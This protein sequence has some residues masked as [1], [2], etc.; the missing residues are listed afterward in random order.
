MFDHLGPIPKIKLRKKPI[1][2]RAYFS[3][4]LLA[5]AFYL[6]AWSVTS[7]SQTVASPNVQPQVLVDLPV[8]NQTIVLGSTNL[9]L[10]TLQIKT[11]VKG[12]AI[13]NIDIKSQGIYQPE[14]L[15]GLK[16]FH[17]GVQLGQLS[18]LDDQGVLHFDLNGY[19]LPNGDNQI[20]L[21]A[22]DS[23]NLLAGDILN[24]SL[25]DASSI[26]WSYDNK[27]YLAQGAWP[28][29][30]GTI[31]VVDQG[32]IWAYNNLNKKDLA[33]FTNDISKLAEFNLAVDGEGLDLEKLVFKHQTNAD[34][35]SVFS[36]SS[37][38]MTLASAKAKDGL[39]EFV[40][41]KPLAIAINQPLNLVLLGQLATGDY[42]LEL[43]SASGRGWS[44]GKII[45]LSE[46]LVLAKVISNS[47]LIKF[48]TLPVDKKIEQDWLAAANISVQKLGDEEVA[49]HRLTWRLDSNLVKIKAAK[50]LVNDQ[51]KDLD[52]IISDDKIIAKT[53][54]SDPIIL[55]DFSVNLKLLLQVEQFEKGAFIQTVLLGDEQPYKSD[56]WSDNLLWL[57]GKDMHNAY[58][59]SSLPLNP[60][61]IS[62]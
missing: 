56:Q 18:A 62:N 41:A 3:F 23:N 39:L 29:L 5:L 12:V 24:F 14:F 19:I 42:D 31:S 48:S 1:N 21:S 22:K 27:K 28:L 11:N 35:E 43:V 2:Y 33:V 34:L 44:S 53:A 30:G 49:L 46:N 47:E 45:D 25:E 15:A 7:G 9:S 38:D 36:L 51:I 16:L 40:L 10:L 61:L 6:V 54:W 55:S 4:L 8:N 50:L 17:N 60:Q 26:S 37:A 13:Q 20:L 52:F 59:L 58:A 57:T 32:S